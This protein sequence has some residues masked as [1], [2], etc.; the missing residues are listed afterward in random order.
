M[1]GE[2]HLNHG[3]L[4]GNMA[5]SDDK[6]AFGYVQPFLCHCGSN[7]QVDV[8]V[9]AEFVQ[10]FPLLCLFQ[11]GICV[12][13]IRCKVLFKATGCNI[14]CTYRGHWLYVALVSASDEV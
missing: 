14:L 6:I 10:H 1:T 9:V 2:A 12:E 7:Q 11:L 13:K 3:Y 4:I 5:I 8:T